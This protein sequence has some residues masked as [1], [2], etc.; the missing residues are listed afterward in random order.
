MVIVGGGPGGY[1]AALVGSQLGGEVT[2]IDSDGPRRLGGA[3][4]LR[5]LQDLDR[6]GRGDD[7]GQRVGELGL[8]FGAGRPRRRQSGRP[9]R[10]GRGQRAGAR[11]GQARS[12]KTSP[13]GCCRENVR[14]VSGRGRLDGTGPGDRRHR[15][16]RADASTPTWS[17]WPPAPTPVSCRTP[18]PDGERIL[19]WTQVYAL[20]ELPRTAD[21]R[22]LRAS[23]VR[24]SPARTTPSAATSSWSRPATGCCPARTPTR[25][26]VLE[27]V[28]ARRGMTVLSRSRAPVGHP[29]R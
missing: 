22:R 3:H 12:P 23:P 14:L 5:T 6:D 9:R 8:R 10:P 2:L 28:F 11:A 17:C 13:S 20:T 4:R 1:E 25:R 26:Q 21:R 18:S 7:R 27:D 24:S 29:R 16:R 19:T 15:R